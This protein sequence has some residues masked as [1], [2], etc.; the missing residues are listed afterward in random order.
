ML[1]LGPPI[2]SVRFHAWC[3]VDFISKEELTE[4][5]DLS[6]TKYEIAGLADFHR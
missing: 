2:K 6:V 4:R 5:P 3:P 1:G